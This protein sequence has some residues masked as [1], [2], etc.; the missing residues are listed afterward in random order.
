M[1]VEGK[2]V[3]CRPEKDD[4]AFAQAQRYFRYLADTGASGAVLYLAPET[5]VD[6]WFR[7][8]VRA[9]GTSRIPYGVMGWS[10][11]FMSGISIQLILVI[12]SGPLAA[13]ATLLRIA[14]GYA[15]RRPGAANIVE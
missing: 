15:T 9:S 6:G 14:A 12:S 1:I 10:D 8:L 13:A 11:E 4:Y 5:H 7:K 3:G 2:G